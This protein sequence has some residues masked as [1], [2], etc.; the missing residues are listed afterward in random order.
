MEIYANIAMV[1]PWTL[2]ELKE[3]TIDELCEW[4]KMAVERSKRRQ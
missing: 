3:L 2:K 1:F 4:E